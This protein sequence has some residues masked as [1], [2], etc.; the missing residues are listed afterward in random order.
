MPQ[1]LALAD[2]NGFAGAPVL[3]CQGTAITACLYAPDRPIFIP[4]V[5]DELIRFNDRMLGY[6]SLPQTERQMDGVVMRSF[7]LKNGLVIDPASAWSSVKQIVLINTSC[8]PDMVIS[9]EHLLACLGFRKIDLPILTRPSWVV[10]ELL[11]TELSLWVAI[12]GK[13]QGE[14]RCKIAAHS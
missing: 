8:G 14:R 9:L 7:L 11:W 12:G 5:G 4:G 3:T 2:A 10:I 6:F 13:T 1:A